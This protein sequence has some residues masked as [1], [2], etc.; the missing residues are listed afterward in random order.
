MSQPTDVLKTTQN[1][2]CVLYFHCNYIYAV[3]NYEYFKKFDV[4]TEKND[5]CI[6]LVEYRGFCNFEGPFSIESCAKDTH[7]IIEYA[8]SRFSGVKA[9]VGHSLGTGVTL[10]YCNYVKKLK[11]SG[12]V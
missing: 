7:K 4:F 6:I 5:F 10:E 1:L 2:N 8:N 11:S 3:K 12:F 9:L